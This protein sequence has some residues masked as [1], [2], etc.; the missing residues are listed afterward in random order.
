MNRQSH[1]ET[2]PD[3]GGGPL[4]DKGPADSRFLVSR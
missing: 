3:P 1:L 2:C 4:I